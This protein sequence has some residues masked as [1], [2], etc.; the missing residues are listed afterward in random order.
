MSYE[1]CYPSSFS[2]RAEDSAGEAYFL[3]FFVLGG[4]GCFVGSPI[5]DIDATACASRTMSFVRTV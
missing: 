4:W 5:Q 3:L 1:L 2:L